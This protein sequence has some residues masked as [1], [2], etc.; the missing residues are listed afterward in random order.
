[1]S[2]KKHTILIAVIISLALFWTIWVNAQTFDDPLTLTCSVYPNNLMFE[3]DLI[4]G[5]RTLL[6]IGGQVMWTTNLDPDQDSAV[7]IGSSTKRLLYLYSDNINSTSATTTN[8]TTTNLYI[9][10]DLTVNSGIILGG[11]RRTTWPAG[12]TDITGQTLGSL[13]DVSTTTP[14]YGDLLMWDGSNWTDLATSSLNINTDDTVEG[15]TNLYQDSELTNWIDNVTLG[16]SGEFETESYASSTTSLNTQGTLH[17]GGNGTIE[18]TLGVT[19][20]I[21]GNVTGAL[22]G[23]A[24]TATNLSNYGLAFTWTGL[25]VHSDLRP[26]VLN[27]S[28]TLIDLLT[29]T[30]ATTSDNHYIGGFLQ[31]NSGND[32]YIYFDAGAENFM[33]DDSP[34]LFTLTD[35]FEVTGVASSTAGFRV[36]DYFTVN[37]AGSA[38]TTNSLYV[39]SQRVYGEQD[40]AIVLATSTLDYI[41]DATSTVP[42]DYNSK[43]KT[44]TEIYC[45]T[46]DNTATIG[47]GDGTNFDYVECTNSGVSR[48]SLDNGTYTAR[49]KMEVAVGK[50]TMTQWINIVITESYD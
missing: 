48:T 37:S 18:G 17:I 12:L 9:S 20:Q 5:G 8:A 41:S 47:I 7:R 4:L 34:A 33:W 16:S 2:D 1:M 49:E 46:N 29:A 36:N 6:R 40:R 50:M 25:N 43:A 45:I 42:I 31:M 19:G 26:A 32:N 27:A 21:T 24:D 35:D 22:T 3:D 23:N 44:I 30:S 13:A 39:N 38:T 28:N 10:E 11:T 14:V 15:S